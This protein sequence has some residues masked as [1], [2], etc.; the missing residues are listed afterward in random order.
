MRTI[1]TVAT[2]SQSCTRN[3]AYMVLEKKSGIFDFFIFFFS[4]RSRMEFW[5]AGN[6]IEEEGV[7]EW[8]KS[9]LLLLVLL[10]LFLFFHHHYYHL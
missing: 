4:R 10:L 3:V 8:A 2:R 1:N 7:W 6:D 5:I 9:R